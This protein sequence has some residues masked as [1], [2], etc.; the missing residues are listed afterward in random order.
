M[1]I[2]KEEQETKF[3]LWQPNSIVEIGNN[4]NGYQNH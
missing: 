1:Y 2:I 4:L 3:H